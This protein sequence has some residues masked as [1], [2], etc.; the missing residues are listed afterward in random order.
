M[1]NEFLI[2]GLK[3]TVNRGES[4][5]V[6]LEYDFAGDRYVDRVGIAELKQAL[7]DMFAHLEGLEQEQKG[8]A[9]AKYISPET[10][11]KLKDLGINNLDYIVKGFD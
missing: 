3:V 7:S 6:S 10:A 11:K 4:S 5:S 1:E 8:K 9:V 2:G